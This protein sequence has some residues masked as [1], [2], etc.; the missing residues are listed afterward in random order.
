MKKYDTR[1]VAKFFFPAI[2]RMAL[3]ACV[4]VVACACFYACETSSIEEIALDKA[5]YFL[6][7]EEENAEACISVATLYGEA[8]TEYSSDG[9]TYVL[10]ACF[11]EAEEAEKERADLCKKNMPYADS[12]LVLPKRCGMLYF[13]DKSQK[14]RKNDTVNFL[15][16]L[17]A[18]GQAV[19]RAASDLL[20]G[21]SQKALKQGSA[22]T[23]AVLTDLAAKAKTIGKE[24]KCRVWTDAGARCAD[25]AENLDSAAG[26][27]LFAGDLKY[28]RAEICRL[29]IDFAENFSI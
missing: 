29:Y 8:G 20:G 22:V 17:D 11:S 5:F 12:L 14:R 19:S 27:I 7:S 2:K 10:Y 4:F 9:K 18:C 1:R 6:V 16:S 24:E 23:T 26:G 25:I 3:L 13:R 21:V 28:I 15:S